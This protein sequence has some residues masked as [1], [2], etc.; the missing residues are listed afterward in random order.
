MRQLVN[1]TRFPE[2]MLPRSWAGSCEAHLIVGLMGGLIV[3]H[4]LASLPRA[5]YIS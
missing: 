3:H 5:V 1:P 2:A 4:H